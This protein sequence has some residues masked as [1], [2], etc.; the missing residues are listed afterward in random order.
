MVTRNDG[1]LL[2]KR[3]LPNDP[4][5]AEGPRLHL[6]G[7]PA[8]GIPTKSETH[9]DSSSLLRRVGD[10]KR[11]RVDCASALPLKN[12]FR[13]LPLPDLQG[14][15][16]GETRASSFSIHPGE[17]MGHCGR[18]GVRGTPEQKAFSYN[19]RTMDSGN[20]ALLAV[21]AVPRINNLRP[22]NALDSSTPA[23]STNYKK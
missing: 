7:A 15:G 16:F 18:C 8:C 20:G 22:I 5:E 23:A 12:S 2:S 1:T 9:G 10:A 14:V 11:D 13:S 4:E 3:Y 6:A 19:K 21:V 17:S